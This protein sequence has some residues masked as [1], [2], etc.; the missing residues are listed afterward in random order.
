VCI[1]MFTNFDHD[2]S[3]NK[4]KVDSKQTK[5]G[6]FYLSSILIDFMDTHEFVIAII[7]INLITSFN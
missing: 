3:N 7:L 6:P 4:S 2:Y 5:M 1:S